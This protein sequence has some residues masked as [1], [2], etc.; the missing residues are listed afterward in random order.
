MP[1]THEP[2]AIDNIRGGIVGA[3]IGFILGAILGTIGFHSWVMSR[4]DPGPYIITD[5]CIVGAIFC[6]LPAALAGV[7]VGFART[8][9]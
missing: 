7:V 5:T 4:G 8:A 2:T 3:V 9:Y 6:G 1:A